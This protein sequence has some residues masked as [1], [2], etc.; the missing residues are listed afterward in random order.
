MI[1]AL[2]LAGSSVGVR[3]SEFK[4]CAQS[5]FCGRQRA[6]A[7]LTAAKQ[8][9]EAT[10]SVVPGS[11]TFSDAIVT[12]NVMGIDPADVFVAVFSFAQTHIN[13]RLTLRNASLT[14]DPFEKQTP[15]NAV[16]E[17]RE[18][19]V[20]CTSQNNVLT[21]HS[22]PFRWS[23]A[24]NGTEAVAW[25]SL[26]N[27]YVETPRERSDTGK[28]PAFSVAKNDQYDALRS[29]LVAN[30]WQET[31]NNHI[32]EK[33]NGP[34][35]VGFD[36][37]FPGAQHT[38]G[39]P[40]H[41]SSFA[42]KDTRGPDASYS[43]PYRLYNLD[44]F[45]YELDNPMALY[46]SIPF[47][48]A[49]KSGQTTAILWMN[50]AEMWIDIQKAP[51][52]TQTHWMAET[53]SINMFIFLGPTQSDIFNAYTALSGR[54]QLPQEFAIAYHQCRWNYKDQDDVLQVDQNFDKHNI[55][56]DVLWLDIEHTNGKRYFTWDAEKFPE[57][58]QMQDNLA[59]KGRK[60]VTIV[61]PHLK[62]D[63]TY[64]V[65]SEALAQNLFVRTQ[66][67]SVFDGYCWPGDSNWLDYTNIEARKFWASK[68]T[69]D[70]YLGSTP[71]LYTWNDMNEVKS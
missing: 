42:L 21:I 67:G 58:E 33:P 68:F 46:G 8:T 63:S 17:T 38:Y 27:L 11:W 10:F 47:M 39:I 12:A 51:E 13:F 60:M 53:G 4:T 18:G 16:C 28:E 70:Q 64:A 56:Y 14:A 62:K 49:H 37:V 30:Y 40:E 15:S 2:L 59:S 45:E 41:A 48:M 35:S 69:Y 6:Y 43:D 25:N 7:E 9:L 1:L 57:P 54:P 66:S 52:G 24:H 31:F 34:N 22:S 26:N 23:I 55:P 71:N 65:S 32:D 61:D 5:G 3:R 50:A 20:V 19:L 44:V 36:V 29:E